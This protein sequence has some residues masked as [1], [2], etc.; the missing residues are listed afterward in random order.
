MN[1]RS[2]LAV[3]ASAA[4]LLATLPTS[5]ETQQPVRIG[6][7]LS[8]SGSFAN[9]GRNQLRGYQLCVKHANEKGGVLGRRIELLAATIS[10]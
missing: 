5:G 4:I 2:R 3:W 1:G 6:A 9:L 10:A 8:Q 7:S